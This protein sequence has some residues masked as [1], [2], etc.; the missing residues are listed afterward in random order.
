[1]RAEDRAVAEIAASVADG[2]PVDWGAVETG[3]PAAHRRLVRHLRLVESISTLYRTLP[4]ESDEEIGTSPRL[5]DGPRWGS[6]VLLDRIGTGTSCDVYK[7]LDSSL[8]RHVA[9]KLLKDDPPGKQDG[10]SRV[11]EEARRLA[12][13]RHQHVVQ[14]YGAEEH[15][16]RVGLWMELVSGESLEQIVKTRGPYGAAEAAVVGQQ[17]CA[18]LAAV[19]GAGLLH[20]DVKAQNVLRE[21]GGRIV[22]MDFGTGEELRINAGTNRLVGTPLYLAPEIFRGRAASVQS[23]LYSLGVLLFYLVTGE[24]PVTAGTMEGLARAHAESSMRRLRDVRPDLPDG[25]VA[26]VDRALDASPARRFRTAGDMEL[27]L[28]SLPETT[29]IVPAE[30]NVRSAG[31]HWSFAAAAAVL[32]A[33]TVSLIV[34]TSQATAPSSIGAI[35][36]VAVAPMTAIDSS[37]APPFFAEGLTDQLIST[38]GQIQSLRVKSSAVASANEPGGGG[39]GLDAV[40]QTTL[41]TAGTS[42]GSKPRVRVNARLVEAGSGNV[43]WAQTFEHALGDTFGLQAAMAREIATA[44]KAAITPEEDARL[45]QVRR[46]TAEAETAFLEGRAHVERYGADHARQ[47]LDAF[48]R[49]I[50][51]DPRHA[52]ARAGAARAY[53]TLGNWNAISQPVARTLA[54]E[55][56]QK[57]IELDDSLP[58]AHATL[59]GIS[60]YYDWSW[61]RA[62]AGYLRSLSL[63]PSYRYGRLQYS[64]V[65]AGARR[66]RE[67]IVQAELAVDLEPTSALAL[68]NLGIV[69]Y[70]HRDFDAAELAIRR[71][72]EFERDA[73]AAWILLGRIAEAKGDLTNAR[74]HTSQAAALM[75]EIPTPIRV[76]QLR[77]HALAGE[78]AE[79]LSGLEQLRQDSAVR[80]ILWNPQSDAY[81]HLALGDTE[82]ALGFLAEAL[83]QRQSSLLWLGVDPRMD[84]LRDHP[85]FRDFLRT[86][87]LNPDGTS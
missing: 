27:A 85:R 53:F 19:H 22:L 16:G 61:K 50:N 82:R 68:R 73:P 55:E 1:M 77:L 20:R 17:L 33:L 4:P 32:V 14:V 29:V 37:T 12:R 13:V 25:F 54:L 86:L 69:F 75:Q 39:S 2:A 6:L 59:A 48:R 84:S 26:A 46:T 52:A 63:N 65:L 79:A 28:R 3:V 30:A 35:R 44:V 15:D 81:V 7:A 36:K 45:K 72:M 41:L 58:D 5:P 43:I 51:L 9:L 57:A 71:S 38:L 64:Q 74:Q 11:L 23:D 78:H 83:E 80:G 34:W 24:F 66:T 49:A 67:A 87:G 60:F 47:A 18:A 10:H 21:S 62:E 8:H 56:A 31:R 76:Q 40:L 70:Y 42:A